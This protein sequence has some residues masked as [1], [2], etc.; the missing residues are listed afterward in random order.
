VSGIALIAG[1]PVGHVAPLP[2]ARPPLHHFPLAPWWLGQALVVGAGSGPLHWWLGRALVGPAQSLA[3]VET[4]PRPALPLVI[5]LAADAA[6]AVA[7]ALALLVAAAV[8]AA[9]P[10]IAGSVAAAFAAA[11][12]AAPAPVVAA[13]VPAAA[14]A[15]PAVA[16]SLV[17]AVAAY[18]LALFGSVA[19]QLAGALH[20]HGPGSNAFDLQAA[21]AVLAAH[22][23]SASKATWTG[24]KTGPASGL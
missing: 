14:E 23:W 5:A 8:A 11:L 1:E 4:G 7:P 17:V 10:A 16:A 18:A 2:D 22:V 15:H 24:R 6:A 9:A 20:C 12:T 3:A 21:V 19:A 13:A